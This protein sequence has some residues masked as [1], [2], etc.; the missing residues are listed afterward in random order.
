MEAYKIFV[1]KILRPKFLR[2]KIT[3]ANAYFATFAPQFKFLSCNGKG[4]GTQAERQA[5][6]GLVEDPRSCLNIADTKH[7]TSKMSVVWSPSHQNGLK[8]FFLHLA[9]PGQRT[10]Q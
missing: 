7:L 9:H 1:K 5:W 10:M 4:K 6:C 8:P 2:P 3:P